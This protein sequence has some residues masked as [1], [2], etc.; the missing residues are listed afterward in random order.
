MRRSKKSSV[1]L[2]IFEYQ[3]LR[4]CFGRYGVARFC[5][6]DSTGDSASAGLR[7]TFHPTSTGGS[8]LPTQPAPHRIQASMRPT[9][10]YW[11]NPELP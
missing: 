2:A 5:Y 11:P 9:F 1:D 3:P 4:N 7:K 10:D 8:V 6:C